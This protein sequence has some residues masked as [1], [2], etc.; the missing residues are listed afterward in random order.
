MDSEKK[1]DQDSELFDEE[2]DDHNPLN[3][4]DIWKCLNFYFEKHGLVSH[5]IDSYENFVENVTDLVKGHD[6]RFVIRVTR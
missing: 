1:D 3:N 6:G 4:D 5:Q 2:E